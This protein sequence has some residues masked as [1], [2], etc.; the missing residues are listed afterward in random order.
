[1]QD[2]TIKNGTS[3]TLTLAADA[4]I[5]HIYYA[6]DQIWN[7][8]IN[9]GEPPGLVLETTYGLRARSQRL[10]PRFTEGD[11]GV[12][13]PLDFQSPVVI[14]TYYPN[15]VQLSFSPLVGIQATLTYWI[16]ASQVVVGQVELQNLT[17]KERRLQVEWIGLLVPD[18]NGLRMVAEEIDNVSILHGRTELIEAVLFVAGGA[19]HSVGS[20]TSLVMDINLLADANIRSVCA[21]ASLNDLEASFELARASASRNIPAE[22]TRIAMTNA[23]QIQVI[24]GNTEWND[25][26]D[27]AQT[28]AAELVIK[29]SEFNPQTSFVLT[30]Q[31]D[32]G[33]S[34]IRE[35]T[36]TIS[37]WIGHNAFQMLYLSQELLPQYPEFG[38][39][40]LQTFLSVQVEDGFIDWKPAGYN[41]RSTLAATPILCHLAWWV[42]EH[43]HDDQ[44]LIENF[45]K[46]LKFIE[47]WFQPMMDRD[48]DGIPEWS[49]VF[50]TSYEDNPLFNHWSQGAR[51][52]SITTVESPDLCAMLYNEILALV[53]IADCIGEV[54]YIPMLN[55]KADRL[56]VAVEAAWNADNH[57]YQYW[58]RDGHVTQISQVLVTSQQDENFPIQQDFPQPVRLHFQIKRH[59][60]SAHKL[61]IFI[62][63]TRPAGGH[64][65]ER[66]EPEQ[67]EWHMETGYATSEKIYSRIEK[68]VVEG[69]RTDDILAIRTVGLNSLDQTLLLP[70]WAKLAH[71]D[72]VE[73]IVNSIL[74]NPLFFGN[75]SGIPTLPASNALTQAE[76]HLPFNT[77]IL[78][79]LLRYGYRSEAADILTRLMNMLAANFQRNGTFR[80]VY[81]AEN[82]QGIG[83]INSL[84][85]LPPLNSFLEVLGIRIFSPWKIEISGFNPFP[86]PVTVKYCGTT[87]LRQQKKT[88]LI[89]S[90]GQT[91]TLDETG[92]HLISME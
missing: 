36:D 67:F 61:V 28:I 5:S 2:R 47:F 35:T 59:S 33:F 71:P 85:G 41:Q 62:H 1:M 27:I 34:P 38:K 15:F 54:N 65:V 70:I 10:F 79:G 37:S 29:S 8:V 88:T 74:N 56:Q 68:V 73:D 43:T 16:P 13:S 23:S 3:F 46:L 51:G 14:N 9:R 32:R 75:P 90:D 77:L 82:G 78:H 19:R 40:F 50:Q 69:L 42:Y 31:P 80:R 39:A 92:P 72:K 30:R 17:S 63:G 86:W 44:F 91:V 24:T 58:D 48:K 20:Y 45:H 66:I 64:L 7:L 49:H 76:I 4:R 87:I 21:L 81:L 55:E 11:T 83:E 26:L 60:D 22:I 52:L 84:E 25:L 18:S 89:F 53:R 12:T 6:N 57:C